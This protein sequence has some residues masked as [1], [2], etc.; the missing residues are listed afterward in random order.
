MLTSALLIPIAIIIKIMAAM[1]MKEA[2]ASL[3]KLL[4]IDRGIS[5][6]TLDRK[7]M[8]RLSERMVSGQ[9]RWNRTGIVSPMMT[10]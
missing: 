10:L 6:K 1:E 9:I 2:F 7:M 3:V 4:A 5:T 8:K